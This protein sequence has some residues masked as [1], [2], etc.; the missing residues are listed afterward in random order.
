MLSRTQK[1]TPTE[2]DPNYWI[3]DLGG[4]SDLSIDDFFYPDVQQLINLFKTNQYSKLTFATKYVNPNLLNYS[5]NF[6]T[7]IRFSIMPEQIRKAVNLRTSKTQTIISN[8]NNFYEAGYNVNINLAPVII[9]PNWQQDYTNLLQDIV[10]NTSTSFKK[11]LSFEI[12]F[13]THNEWLHNVNL[14]WNSIGEE[15]LWQPEFQRTKIS[16]YSKMV[17]K[18]Y[19]KAYKEPALNWLKAQINQMIPESTIR[20]AF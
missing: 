1:L 14:Q 16:Q 13:L 8:L 10:D 6:S 4:S 5:P 7:R 19:K 12:I 20:Y 15:F 2:A 18:A 9:Y 11:Q 3:Y 17:N